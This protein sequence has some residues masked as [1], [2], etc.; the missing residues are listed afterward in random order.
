MR[1]REGENM[2]T[3]R[4]K[5]SYFI[6]RQIFNILILNLFLLFLLL[7]IIRA[8]AAKQFFSQQY[9][10]YMIFII[11]FY[12]LSATNLPS[13]ILILSHE[14]QYLYLTMISC[15]YNS[16]RLIYVHTHFHTYKYVHTPLFLY[17]SNIIC[18]YVC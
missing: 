16:Q 10:Q 18:M 9:I 7:C 3:T 15:L 2:I 13:T 8:M 6:T 12:V 4:E 1:E 14:R 17:Y 5:V 11:L